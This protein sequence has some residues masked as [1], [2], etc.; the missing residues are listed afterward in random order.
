MKKGILMK[1]KI[2]LSQ[3]K[4]DKEIEK[5]DLVT[6][7]EE[8]FFK[9]IINLI[10]QY[11]NNNFNWNEVKGKKLSMKSIKLKQ[12]HNNSIEYLTDKANTSNIWFTK[13]LFN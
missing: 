2:N 8:I 3:E 5:Y 6:K 4:Y 7:N 13:T 11:Y 10:N 9:I 1:I 12:F